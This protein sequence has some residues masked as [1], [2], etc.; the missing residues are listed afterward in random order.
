MYV[1]G[2][3]TDLRGFNKVKGTTHGICPVCYDDFKR[4]IKETRENQR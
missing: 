2:K 1:N 4:E 3:W